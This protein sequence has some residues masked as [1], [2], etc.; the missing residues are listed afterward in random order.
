MCLKKIQVQKERW[1]T[2]D[3]GPGR[4]LHRYQPRCRPCL[5]QSKRISR[6][7]RCCPPYAPFTL[8]LSVSLPR[9]ISRLKNVQPEGPP[10]NKRISWRYHCC[11]PYAPF[12][13]SLCLSEMYLSTQKRPAGGTAAEQSQNP[14]TRR[15]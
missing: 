6:R 11:A 2:R 13:L 4:K 10:L 8:S 15:T 9:S 7:Y 5:V 1:Q 3:T 12:T 14:L